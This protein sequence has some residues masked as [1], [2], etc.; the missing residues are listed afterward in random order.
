MPELPP[1]K[2]YELWFDDGGSLRPAGLLSGTEARQ[3][4]LLDGPVDRATAVG[5]TIEPASG[6]PQPTSPPLG[7]IPFAS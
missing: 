5:I 3:S 1:G 6:S 2:A 4:R 7:M